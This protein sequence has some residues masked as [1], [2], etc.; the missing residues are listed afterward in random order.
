MKSTKSGAK[1]ELEPKRDILTYTLID[2]PMLCQ[3]HD[4]KWLL[5]TVRNYS[6]ESL[7]AV[8]ELHRA[9]DALSYNNMRPLI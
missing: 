1:T 7:P 3:L 5:D 4:E 2:F 8:T 6:C 9:F